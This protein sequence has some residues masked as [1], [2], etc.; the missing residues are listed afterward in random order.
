MSK[1]VFSYRAKLSIVKS[2]VIDSEKNQGRWSLGSVLP[3]I[4][5]SCITGNYTMHNFHS[6]NF[7]AIILSRNLIE[8][9]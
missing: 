4:Q 9:C 8:S 6:S 1:L 7:V 5:L 3:S 2:K